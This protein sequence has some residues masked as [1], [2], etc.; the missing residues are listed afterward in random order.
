LLLRVERQTLR[1]LDDVVVFTIR[2]YME[3]MSRFRERPRGQVDS[4]VRVLR[5]TQTDV[6]DYKS[7]TTYV[8]PLCAYLTSGL[9]D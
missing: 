8:E 6:R 2:T 5:E 1:R 3:P 7:I 4:F 9:S